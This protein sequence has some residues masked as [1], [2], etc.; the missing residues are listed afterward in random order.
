MGVVPFKAG[1]GS[2]LCEESD[3]TLRR[4]RETIAA[5]YDPELT[6]AVQR[7]PKGPS[8]ACA[9]CSLSVVIGANPIRNRDIPEA[10]RREIRRPGLACTCSRL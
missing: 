5:D 4:Y 1:V 7:R 8:G 3:E 6:A 10:A 9:R 2:P